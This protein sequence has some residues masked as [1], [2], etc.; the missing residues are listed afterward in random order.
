MGSFLVKL[1]EI[2]TTDFPVCEVFSTTENGEQL[3]V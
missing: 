1:T 2:G 3:D